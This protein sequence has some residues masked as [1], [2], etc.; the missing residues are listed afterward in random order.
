MKLKVTIERINESKPKRS[1]LTAIRFVDSFIDKNGKTDR[2]ILCKCLCGDEKSYRARSV[3]YETLSCG[4]LSSSKFPLSL[5][6][7]YHDMVGRCYNK[8]HISYKNYGM[9]GVVVC[10]E[11]LN[12]KTLFYKWALDNG[13]NKGLQLDKDINGN[14]LMYSPDKCMF[15]TAK[16][17]NRAR[18]Y[19]KRYSFKGQILTL[20]EI[21]EITGIYI[22]TIFLRMK[23]GKSLEEALIPTD[24]SEWGAIVRHIRSIDIPVMDTDEYKEKANQVAGILQEIASL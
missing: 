11:W 16:Q 2:V 20:S 14:G 22:K 4:C 21:S 6:K 19:L 17:N 12:D 7:C 15:V 18:K 3:M 13:Y 10:E 8:L 23:R 24:K 9:K 1:I 5:Q